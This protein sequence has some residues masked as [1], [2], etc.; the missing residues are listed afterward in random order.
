MG[1]ENRLQQHRGCPVS[2]AGALIVDPF[3]TKI[4]GIAIAYE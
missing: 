4:T 3:E 2:A 1:G